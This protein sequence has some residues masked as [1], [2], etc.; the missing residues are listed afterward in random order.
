[1]INLMYRLPGHVEG[2]MNKRIPINKTESDHPA[3]LDLSLMD[4]E[5]IKYMLTIN[6]PDRKHP[7]TEFTNI[8]EF[9]THLR[10]YIANL[11]ICHVTINTYLSSWKSQGNLKP[12]DKERVF[13]LTYEY[14]E[15][16]I[17]SFAD[18]L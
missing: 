17:E 18:R 15:F 14:R 13:Q 9:E 6:H 4:Q 1:M 2:V 10:T 7:L 16:F 11:G 8:S 5:T 3:R 12:F